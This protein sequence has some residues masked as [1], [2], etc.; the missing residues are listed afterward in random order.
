MRSFLAGLTLLLVF[1]S[2][3]SAQVNGQVLS[4]GIQGNYRPDCWN[5]LLVQLR[6]TISESANYQIQVHQQDLDKD[7]V[8]YTKIV[9]LTGQQTQPFWVYFMP[10]PTNGGLSGGSG[11]GASIG[12][13]LRVEVWDE[14]GKRQMAKLPVNLTATDLDPRRGIG[15]VDG[16]RGSR[17]R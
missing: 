10:Q 5:P 15:G 4:I 1:A 8:V 12:D 6:S 2:A 16:G 17:S 9:T 3:G 14:A 13:V 11:Q 7:I